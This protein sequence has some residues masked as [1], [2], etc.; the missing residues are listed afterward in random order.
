MHPADDIRGIKSTRLFQKRIILGVTGSIAAVES[1]KLAREL[2]RHGAE[3]FPVMT[4]SA[5]R[6]IHPDALEFATSNKPIIALTGKTEHVF[7]CGLVPD[8]VD[9]VLISPCT[10]NTLSKIAYGIDDTPVTTFASTAIGSK[11]PLILVPAMHLSMYRHA[12]IQNNIVQLRKRGIII[13]EPDILGKKAKLPSSD[14]ILSQ[15]MR[16]V[17]THDYDTKRVLIIGGATAEPIDTIRILTNRSTGRT[18]VSLALEAFF[19]G[20]DAELWHGQMKEIPPSFIKKQQ[21]ETVSDLI[22]II[23]KRKLTF[24]YIIVCAALAD[25]IPNI[26]NGK[27]ASGKKQLIISC[28][29]APKIIEY[30]RKKAPKAT[31]VAFKAEHQEKDLE[32]KAKELLKKHQLDYVIG[33]ATSAFGSTENNILLIDKNG[34]ISQKKGTKEVVATY[35]FDTLC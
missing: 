6:I 31:L 10:A 3:V 22:Q 18:A 7:Y 17:G 30:I 26:Y 35:I 21:F 16:H 25:Y 9:A 8:P 1:V 12:T 13:L 20:A 19:R 2:I 4:S 23:K 11:I 24:D 27:I 29:P 28:S 15:T 14:Q 32:K 5:T 33:N 34:T